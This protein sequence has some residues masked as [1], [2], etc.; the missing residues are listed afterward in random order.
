MND[1]D[2]YRDLA[3][4]VDDAHAAWDEANNAPPALWQRIRAQYSSEKEDTTVSVIPALV[5]PGYVMSQPT[6][7][8]SRRYP[9]VV[10]TV[11]IVVVL[12]LSS[13]FAGALLR[14]SPESEPRYAA[15]G[16][17]ADTAGNGVCEVEPLTVDEAIAILSDPFGTLLSDIDDPV[18]IG[19]P[20]ELFGQRQLTVGD[21]YAFLTYL[22]YVESVSLD[23]DKQQFS[24]AQPVV[25]EYLDCFLTGTT[26]Q[27]WRLT[28]PL[29]VQ[30]QLAISL[31]T[32]VSEEEAREL[33]PEILLR[34]GEYAADRISYMG[35]APVPGIRVNPDIA[36]TASWTSGGRHQMVQIAISPVQVLDAEGNVVQ[37][38]DLSGNSLT[39][40]AKSADFAMNVIYGQSTLNLQWYVIEIIFPNMVPGGN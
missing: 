4:D 35:E 36:Q 9:N 22:Y 5:S 32:L 10:A 3:V 14:P 28:D 30:F 24:D 6:P 19:Y 7:V 20:A 40:P 15:L 21:P 26:G 12:A 17:Q 39:D 25:N 31:P 23:L 16:L 27:T 29:V 34:P 13:W 38:A 8:D 2:F 18:A 33:L 1:E 11:A 37:E